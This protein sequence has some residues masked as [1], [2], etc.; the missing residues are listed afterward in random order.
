MK[1]PKSKNILFVEDEEELL[2]TIGNLLR[3]TGYEVIA[4]LD[5]ED[6]LMKLEEVTPQLIIAD[7]KL[8]GIDGFS[9][10]RQVRADKRFASVPFVFLTAYNDLKASKYAKQQGAAE[11]ITK[12]FDFE[13]LIARVKDLL[14]V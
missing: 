12:P 8:P 4:V 7:I 6:A 13:Y 11:Y 14:P 3:D 5:A 2:N 1:V 10:F 9:F